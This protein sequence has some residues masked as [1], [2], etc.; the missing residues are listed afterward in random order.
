MNRRGFLRLLP[1]AAFALL[2]EFAAARPGFD[3]E[4]VVSVASSGSIDEGMTP[5]QIN[6]AVR[7]IMAQTKRHAQA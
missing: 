2:A 7:E 6:A 4:N 5:A 1:A 3:A